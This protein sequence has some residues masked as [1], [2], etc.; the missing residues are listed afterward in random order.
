MTTTKNS[1][2]EAYFPVVKF[3]FHIFCGKQPV[4]SFS[5]A[6]KKC[7]MNNNY[8]L[9]VLFLLMAKGDNEF[10]LETEQISWY[11]IKYDEKAQEKMYNY[12]LG[13]QINSH[14]IQV[15][16]TYECKPQNKSPYTVVVL[17]SMQVNRILF[18]GTK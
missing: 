18:I 1:S 7:S 9:W 8:G 6:Q 2:T 11:E 3:S 5:F 13:Y 16:S 14:L 15:S 12:S 17:Y 10:T 4:C